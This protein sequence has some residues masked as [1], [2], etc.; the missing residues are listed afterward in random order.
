MT[1]PLDRTTIRRYLLGELT[2]P[3]REAVAARL[4]EHGDASGEAREVEDDLVAALTRGELHAAEAEQVRRFV[5]ESAQSDR[6]ASALA[7]SQRKTIQGPVLVR[8]LIGIVVTLLIVIMATFYVVRGN[9][10]G[11]VPVYSFQVPPG[12]QATRVHI[13]AG[14]DTALVTIDIQAGFP[15]YSISLRDAAG[16]EVRTLTASQAGVFEIPVPAKALSPGPYHV[17]VSGVSEKGPQPVD[18]YY[19]AIE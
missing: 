1:E 18:H 12:G 6:F 4:R 5:L 14:T 15:G 13:P 9:R 7:Q 10:F 19:F 17:E 16:K 2:G 8:A 3:E 11:N